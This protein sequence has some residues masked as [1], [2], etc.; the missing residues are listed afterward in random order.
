MPTTN[1]ANKNQDQKNISK[2]LEL[3]LINKKRKCVENTALLRRKQQQIAHVL[4]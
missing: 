4:K 1:T 3:R 2:L